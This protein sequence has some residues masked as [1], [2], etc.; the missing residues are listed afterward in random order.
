MSTMAIGTVS[1]EDIYARVEAESLPHDSLFYKALYCIPKALSCIPIVGIF[2]EMIC[3]VAIKRSIARTTDV[4]KLVKLIE[5]KNDYN[6]CS[7]IRNIISAVTPIFGV[8]CIV[9]GALA[10]LDYFSINN[11]QRVIAELVTKGY[12]PDLYVM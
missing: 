6:K 8:F 5:L 3:E 10:I 11:N 9:F 12:K 7:M 2:P 1:D 4:P